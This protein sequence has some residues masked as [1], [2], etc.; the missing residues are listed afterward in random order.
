MIS[1]TSV[2][3]GKGSQVQQP[4][5]GSPTIHTDPMACPWA[6]LCLLMREDGDG[7]DGFVLHHISLKLSLRLQRVCLYSGLPALSTAES[8]DLASQVRA[9]LSLSPGNDLLPRQLL[10]QFSWKLV[11]LRENL[12]RV[13][14]AL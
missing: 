4:G 2:E 7:L 11:V 13:I 14:G 10:V 6:K 5:L 8:A 1:L 3:E 12:D 9:G